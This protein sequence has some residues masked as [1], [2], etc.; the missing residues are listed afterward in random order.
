[1]PPLRAFLVFLSMVALGLQTGCHAQRATVA[2]SITVEGTVTVR[3]NE[4]FT[5][6][7]LETGNHNWYVLDLTPEQRQALVNPSVQRATGVVYAGEWN[8]IPFAH[9]RVSQ[10]QR[11]NR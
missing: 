2:E 8:S 5:A 9:L 3:G 6:V 4:P 11:I 10:I 7:L 1:M